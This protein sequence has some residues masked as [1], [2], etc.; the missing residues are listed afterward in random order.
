MQ[1]GGT[2]TF[3]PRKE[4]T[5]RRNTKQSMKSNDNNLTNDEVPFAQNDFDTPSH[6]TMATSR[7]VPQNTNK[8][9]RTRTKQYFTKIF[10]RTMNVSHKELLEASDV[11]IVTKK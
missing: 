4:T 11:N 3:K 10:N 2:E 7:V 6:N 5:T 1:F 8:I 9:Q